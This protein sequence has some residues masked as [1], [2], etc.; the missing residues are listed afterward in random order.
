MTKTYAQLAREIAALQASAQRQL[1]LEAK[2]AIAKINE[3][4]AKY[5]LTAGDLKFAA[6]SATVSPL[7][8]KKTKAANGKRGAAAQRATFSDGNGNQWG[9]RG[10]RPAWLRNAI[11]AGRT[12]ES[13]KGGAAPAPVASVASS[14]E[15]QAPA[16]SIASRRIESGARSAKAKSKKTS[17]A[18]KSFPSAAIAAPAVAVANPVKAPGKNVAAKA[19]AG[20]DAGELSLQA[21][22]PPV[23]KSP[24]SKA[25][26]T[27]TA[28]ASNAMKQSNGPKSPLAGLK[29][30]V[31]VKKAAAQKGGPTRKRARSKSAARKTAVVKNQVPSAPE[32]VTA[33]AAA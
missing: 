4:I 2:G 17:A 24:A 23:K 16:N 21:V 13:F 28:R 7:A 30:V 31:P 32:A 25:G 33:T 10:P 18:A 1:A 29:S 9:G 27:K 14:L 8:S 19:R 3:T 6:T 26:A 11:A 12:L 22:K 15:K 5:S 20:S